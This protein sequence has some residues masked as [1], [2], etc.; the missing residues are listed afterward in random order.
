MESGYTRP[1]LAL[2][3]AGAGVVVTAALVWAYPR[4]RPDLDAWP[5]WTLPI[6]DLV[7]L[8]APFVAA[9][10]LAA[11]FAS[12][13]LARAAGV[14]RWVW[15]DIVI[16]IG[17]ALV[18]R[19]AAEFAPATVPGRWP[20]SIVEA[21]T[22]AD[23]ATAATAATA[24]L[25]VAITVIGV[26]GITPLVE[27]FFFR[28]LLQ[29]ALAQQLGGLGRVVAS[30]IAIVVPTA[31]FASLHAVNGPP[32]PVLLV[33]AIGIGLGA[34]IVTAVTGRLGGAIAAHVVNNAI[35]AMLPL[36]S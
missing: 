15:T 4:V 14:R 18:V 16:G 29:R 13:G 22:R 26:V 28:G 24:T 23:A 10:L 20:G 35:V 31:V 32:S 17:I 12:T 25:A 9:V 8:S 1:G 21:T 33:G 36:F 19:A 11:R 5:D 6:V 2:L 27:E 30:I 3:I 7:V 34:G